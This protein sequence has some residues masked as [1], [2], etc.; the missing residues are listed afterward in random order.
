VN[1]AAISGDLSDEGTAQFCL[2]GALAIGAAALLGPVGLIFAGFA[3]TD[4]GRSVAKWLSRTFGDSM[5]VKVQ[6]RLSSQLG[7]AVEKL[8]KEYEDYLNRADESIETLREDTYT[9]LYG[10]S[11]QKEA[12]IKDLLQ[13]GERSRLTIRPLLLKDILFSDRRNHHGS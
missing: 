13:L 9:E 1:D 5:S 8:S 10:P 3:V 7:T 4:I 12:I 6:K 11:D 2:G